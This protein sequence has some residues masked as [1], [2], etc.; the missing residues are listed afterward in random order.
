M[1][2][3]RMLAHRHIDNPAKLNDL[4]FG[5]R[6]KAGPVAVE[7]AGSFPEIIPGLSLQPIPNPGRTSTP[8]TSSATLPLA[9]GS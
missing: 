3:R 7:V 1:P 2:G 5:H 6:P 8:R 4:I 9:G